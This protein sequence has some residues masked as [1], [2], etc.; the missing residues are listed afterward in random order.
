MQV[1]P[2]NECDGHTGTPRTPGAA[3]PVQIGLFII[4]H[5]VVDHVCDIIDID[6]ARS[7]IGRDQDVFFASF[8]RCHGAFALVLV[9]VAVHARC[10]KTTIDQLFL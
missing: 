5:G 3:D 7:H 9:E 2:V 8:K 1:I 10:G 6:T 4:G